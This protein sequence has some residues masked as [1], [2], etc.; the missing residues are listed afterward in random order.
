MFLDKIWHTV[1]F[2]L[3]PLVVVYHAVC[4]SIFLNIEAED[5]KG[6]EKLGNALLT[7]AH[8][9]FAGKVAQ[10]LEEGYVIKQKFDYQSYFFLKTV[11]ASIA[12]PLSLTMGSLVKGVAY[13]SAET[14]ARH[15]R[16]KASLY[17]LVSHVEEY[18]KLG[19]QIEMPE[20]VVLKRDSS[21]V[22]KE[23][24]CEMV[25]LFKRYRIVY[26]LKEANASIQLG[27]LPIDFENV[28]AALNK[29]NGKKYHV[30]D[31]SKRG[32]PQTRLR[33]YIKE[34]RSFIDLFVETN[35]KVFPLKKAV[36]DGI[37]VL[38]PNA[39]S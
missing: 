10:P 15:D 18:Q 33:L 8:Y 2:L 13:F 9:L 27:I 34:N 5:A 7:P 25:A 31:W 36:L 1:S 37:E 3:M 35:L 26:W 19:I 24:L 32:S 30:Q 17:R 22:E 28:R 6:L 14:R 11:V 12:S 16:L 21:D 39:R 20:T 23:T 29:L 38:I 4:G